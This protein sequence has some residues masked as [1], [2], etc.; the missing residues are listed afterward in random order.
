MC[1][2]CH[3]KSNI[4]DVF[5][6][7][8]SNRQS[9][10]DLLKISESSILYFGVVCAF[11]FYYRYRWFNVRFIRNIDNPDSTPL[12]HLN[13]S[14]KKLDY[15]HTCTLYMIVEETSTYR[16]I[17]DVT[18]VLMEHTDCLK[19][20]WWHPRHPDRALNRQSLQTYRRQNKIR[21]TF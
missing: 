12:G 5:V 7:T 9:D 15:I 10:H 8:T 6:L 14:P 4:L 18:V 13:V 20:L 19:V 2:Q 11:T 21:T 1:C 16:M 17:S 3:V